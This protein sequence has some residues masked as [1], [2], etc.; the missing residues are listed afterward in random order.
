MLVASVSSA[1]LKRANAALRSLRAKDELYTNWWRLT[2]GWID[3]TAEVWA[4]S[5]SCR[6]VTSNT[7]PLNTETLLERSSNASF[8]NSLLSAAVAR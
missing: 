6:G 8:A 1:D 5:L 7:N 3:C 2:F 4:S